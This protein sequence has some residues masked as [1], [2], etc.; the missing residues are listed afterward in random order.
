LEENFPQ[1]NTYQQVLLKAERYCAYQE[2]SCKELR[3]KLQEWEISDSQ[4]DEIISRLTED[5][6][7]NE[8]RFAKSFVRGKFRIK[9]WGRLKIKQELRKKNIPDA[10]I[11]LALLEINDDEY[12]NAIQL[13]ASKKSKEIKDSNVVIKKYKVI[14]F[15]AS[16][17]F[18]HDIALDV[19][20]VNV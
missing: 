2:R 10:L 19:L 15:L 16:R 12:I 7:L 9:R 8:E 18:E 13:L 3:I 14:R 11:K 17:G 20:K 5:N 4:I 6:Y 1:K